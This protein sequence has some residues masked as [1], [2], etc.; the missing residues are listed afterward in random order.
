MKDEQHTRDK[1]AIQHLYDNILPMLATRIHGNLTEITPLFHDFGLE[2][3]VDVW[4]KSPDADED[5]PIGIENGNVQLMGLKLRL[6]GFQSAAAPPFNITKDLLFIL[7]H[8]TYEVGPDKNTIWVE[9]RYFEKWA[10]T[11]T[12]ESA[13]RWCDDLVEEITRR[14]ESLT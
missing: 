11:E 4:T 14:L 1:D 5:T 3:V 12:A 2:R 8:S 10:E 9:K 6:E 7:G 13:Q